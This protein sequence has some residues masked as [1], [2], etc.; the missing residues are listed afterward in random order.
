MRLTRT[1]RLGTLNDSMRYPWLPSLSLLGVGFYIAA[2]IILCVLGG[3]W[4]DEKLNT[5]PLWLIIGFVLGIA[6]AFFGVY[7][8]IKPLMRNDKKN[9]GSK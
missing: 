5:G 4:L 8:M 3:H 9:K 6:I 7:N 2:C 1:L